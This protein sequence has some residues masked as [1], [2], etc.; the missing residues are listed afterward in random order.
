M[1]SDLLFC[2]KLKALL[3]TFAFYGL[4]ST[5]YIWIFLKQILFSGKVPLK[6]PE[7]FF[8]LL[9]CSQTPLI[10]TLF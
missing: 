3:M 8:L 2:A 9:K 7:M 1:D 10:S 6:F 4:F 5:E